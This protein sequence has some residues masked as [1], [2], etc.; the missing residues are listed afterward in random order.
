MI[1]QVFAY[2]TS[3]K[4]VRRYQKTR[5]QAPQSFVKI[6]YDV[7]CLLCSLGMLKYIDVLRGYHAL[8]DQKIEIDRLL[9]ELPAKEENGYR[10]NLFR[11]YKRQRL[12]KL[13]QGAEAAW[14]G[15]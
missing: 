7:P 10:L 8:F 9:P 15:D 4:M 6:T 3:F 13:I 12:E 11:L 1:L 14:E 2:L 5:F